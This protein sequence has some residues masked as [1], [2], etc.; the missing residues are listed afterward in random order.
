MSTIAAVLDPTVTRGQA[1]RVGGVAG[2]ASMVKWGG[3]GDM[4]WHLICVGMMT[5]AMVLTRVVS[6]GVSRVTRVEVWPLSGRGRGERLVMFATNNRGGAGSRHKVVSD[7]SSLLGTCRC[8]LVSPSH[9]PEYD[10]HQ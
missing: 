3:G 7:L 9:N 10:S 2:V 8:L 1:G 4:V 5:M 6:E